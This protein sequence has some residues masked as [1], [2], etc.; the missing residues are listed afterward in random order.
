MVSLHHLAVPVAVQLSVHLYSIKFLTKDKP[1][2]EPQLELQGRVYQC[3]QNPNF[4][5]MDDNIFQIFG[6][7]NQI[8]SAPQ[9]S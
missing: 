8:S 5:Q 1:Q 6:N 4:N 2:H 7:V 9:S 3:I